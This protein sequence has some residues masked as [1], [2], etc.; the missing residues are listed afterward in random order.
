MALLSFVAAE[1]NIVVV[2]EQQ[3]VEQQPAGLET[4]GVNGNHRLLV[5]GE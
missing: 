1:L 3:L 5:S 4:R 2:F